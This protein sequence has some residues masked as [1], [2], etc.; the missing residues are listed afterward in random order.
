MILFRIK[1]SAHLI[2]DCQ[3][4]VEKRLATIY[5]DDRPFE[6]PNKDIFTQRIN[7]R[8]DSVVVE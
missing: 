3:T 2:L 8:Q 4:K 6:T 1:S 5:N 7:I